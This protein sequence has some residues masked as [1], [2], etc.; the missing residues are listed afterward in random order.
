MF[1]CSGKFAR[2]LV[3]LHK[4]LELFQRQRMAKQIALIEMA[5]LAS[6]EISLRLD[7]HPFSDDRQAQTLGQGDDKLCNGGVVGIG[8]DVSDE[9]LVY[10]QLVQRQSLQ[11][12]ERRIARAKIIQ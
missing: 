11:I 9:T 5:A 7:F 12:G 4:F 3:L 2:L 8:E 6:E 1:K 10:F